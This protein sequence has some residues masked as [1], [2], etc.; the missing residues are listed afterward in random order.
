MKNGETGYVQ[1]NKADMERLVRIFQENIST[2][3]I[4][5]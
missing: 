4:I 2:L 3:D 1:L 5:Y